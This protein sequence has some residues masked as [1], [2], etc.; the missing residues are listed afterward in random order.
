[1][2]ERR[3]SKSTQT[4]AGTP[5]NSSSDTSSSSSGEIPLEKT[6]WF[7]R[8]NDSQL[9][10]EGSL[11]TIPPASKDP[12]IHPRSVPVKRSVARIFKSPNYGEDSYWTDYDGRSHVRIPADPK[13]T[14]IQKE[15][16]SSPRPRSKSRWSRTRRKSPRSAKKDVAK[17]SNLSESRTKKD[18]GKAF[19]KSPL[20][21]QKPSGGAGQDQTEDGEPSDGETSSRSRS[22]QQDSK[23]EAEKKEAEKKEAEK[24][25]AEGKEAEK[26]GEKAVWHPRTS[27]MPWSWRLSEVHSERRKTLVFGGPEEKYGRLI[28]FAVPE[29]P[30]YSH[31][32]DESSEDPL[33]KLVQSERQRG[34]EIAEDKPYWFWQLF[35]MEADE[36][37]YYSTRFYVIQKWTFV[38]LMLISAICCVMGMIFAKAFKTFDIPMENFGE[39]REFD[40]YRFSKITGA[41]DIRQLSLVLRSAYDRTFQ[42][43]VSSPLLL[44]GVAAVRAGRLSGVSWRQGREVRVAEESCGQDA[45]RYMNDAP[46][47]VP[48][49][50]PVAARS[51]NGSSPVVGSVQDSAVP[52]STK[53]AAS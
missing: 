30:R 47:R 45:S 15:Q 10:P 8:L 1:M 4:R 38:V 46:P 14:T 9:P 3:L 52:A 13:G 39:D 42:Y 36:V 2:S 26:K 5:K 35:Q 43:G 17:G 33:W 28:S 11:T 50:L 40:V 24:K 49:S 25:E 12:T 29:R 48:Q 20:A 27:E 41:G 22:G 23:G 31:D 7:K 6:L 32:M 34:F 19:E 44:P 37:A 21:D 16:P 53:M 18:V 51:V